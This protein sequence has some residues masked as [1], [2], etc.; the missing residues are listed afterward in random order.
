MTDKNELQHWE[1]DRPPA[2]RPDLLMLGLS[3][4]P[5]ICKN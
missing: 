5:I 2:Y 4:P 1:I 3:M